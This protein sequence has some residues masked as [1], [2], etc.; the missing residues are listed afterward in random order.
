MFCAGWLSL[1]DCLLQ[2]RLRRFRVRERVTCGKRTCF[3]LDGFPR[4]IYSRPGCDVSE[5]SVLSTCT[6]WRE[7][8]IVRNAQWEDRGNKRLAFLSKLVGTRVIMSARSSKHCRFR[9]RTCWKMELFRCLAVQWLLIYPS[10]KKSE[11]R[12]TISSATYCCFTEGCR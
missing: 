6:F 8:G 4:Q 2:T 10:L 12:W 3:V 1:V 5:W 11:C 7:R 9:S